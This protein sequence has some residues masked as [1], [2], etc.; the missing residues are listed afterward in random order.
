MSTFEEDVQAVLESVR[1]PEFLADSEAFHTRV[2]SQLGAF[3]AAEGLP[4]AKESILLWKDRLPTDPTE[5]GQVDRQRACLNRLMTVL[6][7][8]AMTGKHLTG[9]KVALNARNRGLLESFL[10]SIGAGHT[11]RSLAS[12]KWA[13]TILLRYL[14]G[15]GFD[16]ADLDFRAALEFADWVRSSPSHKDSVL[17]FAWTFVEFLEDENIVARRFSKYLRYSRLIK[18]WEEYDEPFRRQAS[19][20]RD[21]PGSIDLHALS[22]HIDAAF[23]MMAESGYQSA[24]TTT[25]KRTYLLLEAF[26][27]AN[28]LPYHNELARLWV[29]NSGDVLVGV[30]PMSRRAIEIL[31]A[32]VCGTGASGR[33]DPHGSGMPEWAKRECELF[34]ENKQRERCAAST[35]KMW[36]V[37]VRAIVNYADSRGVSSFSEFTPELVRRFNVQDAHSTNASKNA[38][39]SRIRRFLRHLEIRRVAPEGISQAL[40]RASAKGERLVEVLD[41]GEL[42][43]VYDYCEKAETARELRNAAMVLLGL[44]MGLRATDAVSLRLGDIDWRKRVITFEQA[45]TKVGVALPM[46]VRVGNAIYAYLKDGRARGIDSD[47]VFVSSRHPHGRVSPE[48]ARRALRA[49]LDGRGGFHVLRRTYASRT[50]R[51]TSDPVIVAETL[52]HSGLDSVHKYISF[53]ERNMRRCPIPLGS[54]GIPEVRYE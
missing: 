40:A 38:Y 16:V 34:L 28:S 9:E 31:R 8:G 4:Y 44:E 30:L 49:I 18:P 36:E 50:M 3:L 29:E 7:G 13:A 17:G 23:T 53:D 51:G 25:A 10:A 54:L 11:E 47:F 46:P 33:R 52:G 37:A 35:L 26:L 2:Y 41:E 39:N 15:R 21:D 20:Y 19:G 5:A 6:G 22:P 42:K 12:Y 14:Q 27:Q 48:A 43:A 45:K 24:F 1:G 32:A